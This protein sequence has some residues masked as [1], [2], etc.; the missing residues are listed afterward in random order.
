MPILL[1]RICNSCSATPGYGAHGYAVYVHGIR[2][3]DVGDVDDIGDV[4]DNDDVDT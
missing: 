2:I 3:D 1:T 4:D